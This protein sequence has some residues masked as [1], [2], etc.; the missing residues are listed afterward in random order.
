LKPHKYTFKACLTLALVIFVLS[1]ADDIILATVFGTAVFGFGSMPFYLLLVGS[2]VVSIALWFRRRRNK[3]HG[4]ASLRALK[5]IN[6][7]RQ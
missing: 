1:P 5:A 7:M 4:I 6:K 2:S 3:Q